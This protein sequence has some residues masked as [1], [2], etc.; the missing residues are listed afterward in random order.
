MRRSLLLPVLAL[1]STV[2]VFGAVGAYRIISTALEASVQRHELTGAR[3]VQ[4]QIEAKVRDRIAQ[5][6]S[7]AAALQ[8]HQ[9]IKEALDEAIRSGRHEP[10]EVVL[11]P[12]RQLLK[13][14]ILEVADR[15]ERVLYRAHLPELRGDIANIWGVAEA[16]AGTSIVVGAEG[17]SGLALRAIVPLRVRGQVLGAL[18]VGTIVDDAFARG[19]AEETGQS[20]SF[21]RPTGLI[22]SSLSSEERTRIDL[23]ALTRSV[24]D[25]GGVY[26]HDAAARRTKAYFPFAPVDETFGVVIGIDS[27]TGYVLMEQTLAR[28][29]IAYAGIGL[30]LVLLLTGLFVR[31]VFRPLKSLQD[32]ADSTVRTMFGESAPV[33]RG[34]EVAAVAASFRMMRERLISHAQVLAQAKES[35]EATSRAK[36]EFMAIMSHEI[37]TPMNGVMGMTELL[38]DADLDPESR[39]FAHVA[40]DSAHA[41][42][43][44]INDVLDFSKIEAGKMTLDRIQFSPRDTVDFVFG[45]FANQTAVKGVV[46]HCVVDY[47]V[48]QFL[49]GDPGRLRQIVLNLVGNAVK[50]TE[51]GQINIHVKLRPQ[52]STDRIGLSF[53]VRD[54][55]I[56]MTPAQLARVFE[57]FTQADG[58]T[59]RKF[60]G[61]GLG[62]TVAQ[63]LVELM[64]GTIQVESAPGCGSAFS[65]IALFEQADVVTANA[66]P[67]VIAEPVAS[68]A[69]VLLAEDNPVNRQVALKMLGKMEFNVAVAENGLEAVNRSEE[70]FEVILMDCH[71]PEMDGFEAATRIRELEK[72]LGRPR[73]PIIAMTANASASDRE[74]CIAAGMDDHLGK[75][76]TRAQLVAMMDR[77]IARRPAAELPVNELPVNQM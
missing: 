48:P 55:G 9:E 53:E 39:H 27:S 19:I 15:S 37:R 29:R 45:L 58:S 12:L 35:A 32:E 69:R 71:M 50:F 2:L 38:L 33:A 4:R 49:V 26:V 42:L 64:G 8:G 59:T 61:T 17:V 66:V 44:I 70:G 13:V 68:Q 52:E 22:A 18:T 40:H 73:V 46:L 6:E 34:N 51:A 75:P 41:L 57:P 63:R 76:Y 67:P 10:L 28:V 21:G 23:G 31:Y 43:S 65:F 7:V 36:S 47:E 5:I 25:K 30:M 72:R 62:L 16:V 20:I 60:G 74:Q 54:T 1:I 11:F 3:D 14:S 24:T 56:G 77:W